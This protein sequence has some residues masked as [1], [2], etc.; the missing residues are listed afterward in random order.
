MSVLP[1]Q[2]KMLERHQDYTNHVTIWKR[3]TGFVV[4]LIVINILVMVVAVGLRVMD[5]PINDTVLN[6]IVFVLYFVFVPYLTKGYTVGSKVLKTRFNSHELSFKVFRYLWRALLVFFALY[7]P[8]I[9]VNALS[10]SLLFF[11]EPMIIMG[12]GA[13]IAGVIL[14][15]MI[16]WI[17][18]LIRRP[19]VL[20]FEKMSGV[21][22]DSN[23]HK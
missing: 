4:D 20:F 9:V 12:G 21:T 1:N 11:E 10:E 16:Y 18:L 15:G 19:Y 5:R 17:Q 8:G 23:Y 2:D 13:I 6:G 7:S 3:F 22:L 14:F